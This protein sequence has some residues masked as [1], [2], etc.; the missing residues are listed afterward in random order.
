MI[1]CN[2][3]P[4]LESLRCDPEEFCSTRDAANVLGVSLRTIQMWVESGA[5]Q[6]WKTPGGHR[7]ITVKSLQT[8]VKERQGLLAEEPAAVSGSLYDILIVDDDAHMLRLYELEMAGWNLP[9]HL[10]FAKNGLDGL[11]KIGES[12]PDLLVTD[13]TMP[14]IDG[15]AMI[16]QLGDHETYGEIAII[17]VTGL[18]Q[19][20]LNAARLA[21][22]IPVFQKPLAFE[23]FF[24]A[25][26]SALPHSTRRRRSTV[27]TC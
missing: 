17:V 6:A 8:M 5:L 16:R 11:L 7:R 26:K 20:A 13:L 27:S 18:D 9:L 19:A 1:E 21:P 15:F 25:V 14:E 10:R 2:N 3:M 24:L 12:R 4:S 22:A 23:S